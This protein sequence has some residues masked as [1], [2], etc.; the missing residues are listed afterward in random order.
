MVPAA[1]R[2]AISA[3]NHYYPHLYY[4]CYRILSYDISGSLW[5]ISHSRF[6]RTDTL[7][8]VIPKLLCASGLPEEL[9]VQSQGS[10]SQELLTQWSCVGAQELVI[11]SVSLG[12]S[13]EH[14]G[15]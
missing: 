4:Y 13:D 12:V 6:R 15:Q 11:L 14:Q 2:V 7:K 9:L 3:S 1:W 10:L 8:P 5:S